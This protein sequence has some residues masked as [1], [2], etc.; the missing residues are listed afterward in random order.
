MW[1]YKAIGGFGQR[2]W[3]IR[4]GSRGTGRGLSICLPTHGG[5]ACL[6]VTDGSC[7]V[8]SHSTGIR[9]FYV[10]IPK[11]WRNNSDA[12]VAGP[13]PAGE[14]T[15]LPVALQ[16]SDVA[17]QGSFTIYL[18]ANRGRGHSD[19]TGMVTGRCFRSKRLGV[20]C[21]T[22]GY[23]CLQ[24]VTLQAVL[25]CFQL[26]S[27]TISWSYSTLVTFIARPLL[28]PDKA[29]LGFRFP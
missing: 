22:R 9:E 15:T 16:P 3:I 18:G 24:S 14:Y 12:L 11:S 27:P 13:I 6:F 1:R 26:S 5:F 23:A 21:W 2:S 25:A 28:V 10:A 7:G 4:L 19:D 29:R 17:L 20:S 8:S